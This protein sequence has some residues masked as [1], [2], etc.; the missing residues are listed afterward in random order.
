ML[1]GPREKAGP[2]SHTESERAERATERLRENQR[3]LVTDTGLGSPARAPKVP[4]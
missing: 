2:H 1:Q 3:G 4:A